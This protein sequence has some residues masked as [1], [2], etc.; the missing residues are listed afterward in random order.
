MQIFDAIRSVREL[1][2]LRHFSIH[3]GKAYTHW[4]GRYGAFLKN[5]KLRSFSSERKIEAFLTTL[6]LSGASASTQNQAFNALLF[7]YREV[8]KQDLGEGTRGRMSKCIPDPV[9]H[10]GFAIHFYVSGSACHHTRALGPHNN[11]WFG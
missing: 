2:M 5:S 9:S 11:G 4:L 8:L 3:T 7:F 10:S 1:C 6:A